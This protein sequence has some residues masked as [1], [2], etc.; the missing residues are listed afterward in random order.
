MIKHIKYIICIMAI[1]VAATAGYASVPIV[2]GD[3]GDLF[4]FFDMTV[5]KGTLF[6]INIES[7]PTTGY[8]WSEYGNMPYGIIPAGHK[9]IQKKGAKDMAGFPSIDRRVYRAEEAGLYHFVLQYS[10]SW[11]TDV[12]PVKYIVCTITVK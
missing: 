10:R 2:R 11:E 1:I 4:E 3:T 7:N 9:Y 8:E 12:P 6:S 5:D